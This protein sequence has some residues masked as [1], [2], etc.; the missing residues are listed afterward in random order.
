LV[1]RNTQLAIVTMMSKGTVFNR[2]G[3][4]RGRG[5]S[6]YATLLSLRSLTPGR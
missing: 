2:G 6:L 5:G 4:L 3:G 1:N